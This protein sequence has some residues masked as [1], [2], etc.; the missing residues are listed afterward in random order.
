[1]PQ[2][3]LP[4]EPFVSSESLFNALGKDYEDVF[5]HDAGLLRVV[6][7]FISYLSPDARV[8]DCGSG[9]GKPVAHMIASANRSVHGID[10]SEAMIE[11]SRKQVPTATFEQCNMLSY[12][13]PPGSFG[14]ATA[15]LSLFELTRAQLTTMV[16]NWARW[17]RPGGY[18]LIAT[19]GAEDVEGTREEMYD[20]DGECA[21]GI[22][23]TF[24][25]SRVYL[26]LF[27]KKGWE[28]LLE[29]AGF[30][31]VET[32]RDLFSPPKEAKCDEEKHLFLIARK[33]VE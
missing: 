9:T 1:M 29:G 33:R 3:Y 7:R 24:M 5:G 31:I 25:G 16:A 2:A 17:L 13:P 20:E 11:L 6:E 15:S 26:T 14:G 23:F 22:P 8:L 12:S 28:R 18:L 30:E 21:S 32:Q 19:M 4:G 10:L 27:T